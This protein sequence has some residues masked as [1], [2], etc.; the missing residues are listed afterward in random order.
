[1]CNVPSYS[2]LLT[3]TCQIKTC[4]GTAHNFLLSEDEA[5]EIFEHQKLVIEQNWDAVCDEASLSEVD[6]NLFWGRQFLNPFSVEK[7]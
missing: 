6:K 7:N 1:M 4:L 2:V 3:P 5:C